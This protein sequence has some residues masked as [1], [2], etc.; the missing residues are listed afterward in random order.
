LKSFLSHA[1]IVLRKLQQYFKANQSF[2]PMTNKKTR[3]VFGIFF[4]DDIQ[5]KEIRM[6]DVFGLQQIAVNSKVTS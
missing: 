6:F 3:S 2:I 5:A 1:Q 4:L